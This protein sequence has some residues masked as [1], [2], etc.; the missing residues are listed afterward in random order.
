VV[1][2]QS[3]LSGV[4]GLQHTEDV[5]QAIQK[6]DGPRTCAMAVAASTPNLQVDKV[7]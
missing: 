2:V 5:A 6:L 7:D 3:F 4:G 1:W